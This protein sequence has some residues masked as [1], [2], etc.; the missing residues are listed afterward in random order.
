MTTG[1]RAFLLTAACVAVS[2]IMAGPFF[3]YSAA[4]TAIYGGDARLVL[5]TLAWD[6]HA[7]LSRVPLFDSNIFY[8]AP[9]S[10]VY[11]EH[12]FGVSLFSLPIYALTRNPV[13]AYN[14]LWWVSF[15]L[16]LGAM[17][18]LLRRHVDG[19]IAAFGGACLYTFS[20]YK[21]LHAY[22]HL[23]LLWTW[24][25]PLSIVLLERWTEQ[26]TLL[27]A[28]AWGASILLQSLASWYLAVMIFVAH[29]PVALFIGS[30][31][32]RR[33]RARH[34]WQLAVALTIVALIVWPFAKPY[35]ILPHAGLR[36]IAS[37]SADRYS[38]LLPPVNTVAGRL[39]ARHAPLP[40]MREAQRSIWGEQTLF[41]GYA[42]IVLAAIGVL[43]LARQR[44]WRLLGTYLTMAVLALLLS[45]GPSL[46]GGWTVFTLLG[47]VPGL[48]AFRAPARF[49]LLVLLGLSML[50]AHGLRAVEKRAGRLRWA[51]TPLIVLLMLIE[52]Y[53]VD[54][55]G[56]KPQPAPIPEV[57]R[58]PAIRDARAIVSLPDY[59]GTAEWYM[60]A[61]YL[62]YSTAHWRPIVNGFGRTEPPGFGHEISHMMAFPGPNNARTMRDLGV[63]LI[64]F[65]AAR[66]AGGA[67]TAALATRMNDYE[68]VA[69]AGDDYVFR[70]RPL[71]SR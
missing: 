22:G 20:F 24:L 17:F 47:H 69:R 29:I 58:L 23:H 35:L 55:P 4:A 63:D 10:L 32:L 7:V 57:Y 54:V 12:L 62:Y 64:V 36:E 9:H 52:W 59:R 19:D 56:G 46:N 33:E 43:S 44:R 25:L 6:N 45:C 30:E 42:A 15:P 28:V 66:A 37:F 27:R 3:N 48:G 60:G 70:V 38:Y 50:A 53:P 71:P 2:A 68:L 21:M 16:N 1:R 49:A 11:N 51:A 67:A 41:I 26:P 14:L 34:M 65:H 40:W 61:D 5:W 18:A 31:W 39:W 8:P 13:L